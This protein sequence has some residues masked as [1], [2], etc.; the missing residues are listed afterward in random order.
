MTRPL[1][2]KDKHGNPYTRPLKIGQAVDA[3][4]VGT[5][6]VA[7]HHMLLSRSFRTKTRNSLKSPEVQSARSDSSI[8]MRWAIRQ[9]SSV[10]EAKVDVQQSFFESVFNPVHDLA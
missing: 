3:A 1:T 8:V 2:K 10:R 5:S 4:I 7:V 6:D 9:E